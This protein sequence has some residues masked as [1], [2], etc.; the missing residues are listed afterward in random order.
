[1]GKSGK[2]RTDSRMLGP[3]LCPVD[4]ISGVWRFFRESGFRGNALSPPGHLLHLMLY[5]EYD[6]C[7]DGREYHVRGGDIIYYH[8]CEEIRT[9]ASDSDFAF[10]S[11]SFLSDSLKPLPLDR[12]VFQAGSKLKKAFDGLFQASLLPDSSG[13]A[14][15]LYMNLTAMIFEIDFWRSSGSDSLGQGVDL[16]RE[17]EN[18]VRRERLFRPALD[19]LAERSGM[20]RASIVRASRKANGM[21]PMKKIQQMRMREAR[22]LLKYS[23]LNVTQV[24]EYLSYPRLHEFSREFSKYFG[25]PPSQVGKN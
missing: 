5:G 23:S 13:R 3:V 22:G 1:M 6:I 21:S 15:A 10:Y 4:S 11:V 20:S 2:G 17:I 25:F 12:R 19:E 9:L 18:I 7:T 14:L 8:D 24:A 16:W